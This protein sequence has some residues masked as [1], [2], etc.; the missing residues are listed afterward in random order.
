MA[1]AYAVQDRTAEATLKGSSG[2]IVK[3]IK[4]SRQGIDMITSVVLFIFIFFF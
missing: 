1:R 2:E 3:F 4:D